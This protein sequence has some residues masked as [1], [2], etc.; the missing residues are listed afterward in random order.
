MDRKVR[1]FPNQKPWMNPEVRRLLR[2]RN[3]AFRS[4]DSGV[5]S[6]ARANLRRGN[7]EAQAE[8]R[9]RIEDHLDSNNS[10]QVWQG[11]RHLTNC[12]PNAGSA[13]GDLRPAEE[14]V[15]PPPASPALA[16]ASLHHARSCTFL[17]LEEH[18]VRRTLRSINPR[19]AAGVFTRIFNQSLAHSVVPPRLKS[20]TIVPLPKKPHISSLN[21]SRP[22]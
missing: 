19:K 15:T 21:D 22:I 14:L 17:I 12:R 3:I 4:G 13:T 2:E 5:Y 1:I 16:S 11:M 6:A 10:R 20:S 18:E 8:D 9:R 7:R